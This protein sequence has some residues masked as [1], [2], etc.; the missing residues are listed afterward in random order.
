MKII[1]YKKINFSMLLVVRLQVHTCTLDSGFFKQFSQFNLS[2]FCL[3]VSRIVVG[4]LQSS[5]TSRLDILANELARKSIDDPK[6][7]GK[8]SFDL[9]PSVALTGMNHEHNHP[10]HSLQCEQSRINKLYNACCSYMC[11]CINPILPQV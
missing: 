7:E 4:R 5:L 2:N 3:P 9:L 6:F 11:I 8:V 1:V 10:I